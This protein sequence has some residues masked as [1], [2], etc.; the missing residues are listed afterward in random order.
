MGV[1]KGWSHDGDD[2]GGLIGKFM[3]QL[4]VEGNQVAYVD[5]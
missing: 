4:F 3:G 1:W 2:V 5:I